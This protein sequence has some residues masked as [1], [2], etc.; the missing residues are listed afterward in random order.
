MA[1][2]VNLLHFPDL[3]TTLR[4]PISKERFV[5]KT[6]LNI[7]KRAFCNCANNM[8]SIP[9]YNKMSEYIATFC[10]KTKNIFV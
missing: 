5:P 2:L 3:P 10:K 8:E 9:Y 6:K 4:S 7:N 1:Y